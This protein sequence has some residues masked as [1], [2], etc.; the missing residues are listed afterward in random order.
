ML[1]ILIGL[2]FVGLGLWGIGVWFEDLLFLLKSIGPIS[3]T[4]GGM[5]A[6]ISGFGSLRSGRDDAK[7]E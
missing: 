6:I 1:A 3:F 2:V 4:L 7:K 5:V